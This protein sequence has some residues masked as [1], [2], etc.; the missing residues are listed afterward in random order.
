MHLIVGCLTET[1]NRAP[2]S[3]TLA[4]YL[5]WSRVLIFATKLY[6]PVKPAEIWKYTGVLVTIFSSE[7]FNELWVK[8]VQC[9]DEHGISETGS[10]S[11]VESWSWYRLMLYFWNESSQLKLWLLYIFWGELWDSASVWTYLIQTSLVFDLL[12]LIFFFDADV[13]SIHPPSL[14]MILHNKANK[15]NNIGNYTG[16]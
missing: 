8:L 9:S 6:L 4:G 3:Q 13:D 14:I 12:F 7:I 15:N 2:K 11:A 16:N 5:V 10:S 1:E